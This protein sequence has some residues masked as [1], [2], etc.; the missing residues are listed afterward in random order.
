MR[1]RW[2]LPHAEL[3]MGNAT[4]KM[5]YVLIEYDGPQLAIFRNSR[6]QRYIGLAADAEG[7]IERW[8]HAPLSPLEVEGLCAR[9][10]PMRNVVC[11]DGM[12][13]IDYENDRAKR[14]YGVSPNQIPSGILPVPGAYLP[15]SIAEVAYTALRISKPKPIQEPRY[16]P[17]TAVAFDKSGS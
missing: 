5:E 1:H 4:L 14:Q 15:K 7:T 3:V 6:K 16:S 12:L 8:I 11:K 13:V 10:V 2:Q 9:G 17:S